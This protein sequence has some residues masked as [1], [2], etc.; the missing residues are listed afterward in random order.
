VAGQMVRLLATKTE[1]YLAVTLTNKGA[2]DHEKVLK[3]I[4]GFINRLKASP[5]PQYIQQ[6]LKNISSID[7]E[8]SNLN[9]PGE[10]SEYLST[11]L[12]FWQGQAPDYQDYEAPIEDIL[13]KPFAI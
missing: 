6:E 11:E 3:I 10:Y 8:H 7:F 2:R 4:F 9:Q 5:P 1:F 12:M 13:W